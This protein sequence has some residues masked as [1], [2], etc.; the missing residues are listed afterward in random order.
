MYLRAGTHAVHVVLV[1]LVGGGMAEAVEHV[2]PES[3]GVVR[4]FLVCNILHEY[5]RVEVNERAFHTSRT[6]GI[7]VYGSE[8]AVGA[9]ALAYHWHAAPS[10]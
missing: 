10:A 6:V 9:V 5:R 4:I 8:R 2:S 3:L 7:E 1:K